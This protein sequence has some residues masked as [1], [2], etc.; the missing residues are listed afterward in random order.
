MGSAHPSLSANPIRAGVS[1][2]RKGLQK[3]NWSE[4]SLGQKLMCQFSAQRVKVQGDG[5]IMLAPGKRISD[6]Q[7]YSEKSKILRWCLGI[8]VSPSF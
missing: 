6:T 5:Y 2:K 3:I 8:K 7:T 4:R 1:L